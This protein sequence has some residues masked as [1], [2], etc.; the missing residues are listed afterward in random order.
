MSLRVQ[1]SLLVLFPVALVAGM[2]L[3]GLSIPVPYAGPAYVIRIEL[4]MAGSRIELPEIR[5][6][7]DLERPLVV[8]DAGHG[9][10]DPGATGAGFNE[11][12]LALSL[13][14]ALRDQLVA[15]GGI[16]VALTRDNDTFLALNERVEIARRLN[17][18]LFLSIH[19]DSAG[20]ETQVAGAT[21][22]TLS[23]KASDETAARLAARENRADRV[24]GVPLE[25]QSE[26]VSAILVDLSQRRSRE[27]SAEFARLIAREGKGMLAFRDNPLRSAAFVVLKAPDVPSVLFEAGYIT[28]PRDAQRLASD[29]GRKVFAEVMS[30]AIRI[31]FVRQSNS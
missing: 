28:N 17:A 16:R 20:D 6:S 5:G 31:Y 30:R 12:S 26:T 3:L 21:V 4:P 15:S 19:A 25:G 14:R 1:L 22:Y 10:H 7:K 29:D 8:I 11:K 23:G 13:A 2:H 24:N 27:E 9:G 18:D